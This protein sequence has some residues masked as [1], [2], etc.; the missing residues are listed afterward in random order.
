MPGNVVS[1]TGPDAVPNFNTQ[2]SG[3]RIGDGFVLT[4]AHVVYEWP[5]VVLLTWR[6]FQLSKNCLE[7]NSYLC[8]T[9]CEQPASRQLN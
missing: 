2:G 1:V 7:G 9:L 8:L 6:C 4:A 3:Y 5:R